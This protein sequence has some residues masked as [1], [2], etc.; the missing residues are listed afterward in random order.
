MSTVQFPRPDTDSHVTTPS[1]PLP[2]VTTSAAKPTVGPPQWKLRRWLVPAA[3]IVTVLVSVGWWRLQEAGH[4]MDADL[5]FHTVE[6][7]DL[8]VTVTE[9][10]NLESQVD[11]QV[12]CEV[13]DI[14]GDNI[15][16]T[17][18][19]W[20]VD[21]GAS[22]KQGDLIV[23]LDAAPIQDRLDAQILAVEEERAEYKQA[24]VA[25]ENQKTQNETTLSEAELAV[26]L[27]QLALEQ[28]GDQ[29]AGTFQIRLAGQSNCRSRRPRRAG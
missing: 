27:A 21:N 15:N 13:D 22:V 3:A 24:E 1:R 23:E 29:E 28:F 10:G 17:P 20:I 4:V 6:R 14:P 7:T 2:K 19:L 9:R 25:Y 18:I 8:D 16:G 12:M 5:V 26:E 11:V